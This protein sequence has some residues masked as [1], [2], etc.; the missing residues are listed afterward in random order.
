MTLEAIQLSRTDERTG[1]VLLH[2]C[3]LSIAAGDRLVITG[4]SGAGKSVLMRA[5]AW[6]DRPLGELRWN[7]AA[8]GRARVPAYRAAVAYVRQRPALLDGSV[9][10][11]LRVPFGLHLYRHRRYEASIA[12]DYLSRAGRDA[13]F[14]AQRADDLS[15]GEQQLVAL[16]RTLQLDPKVLLLDEPTASLDPQTA[17]AVEAMIDHWVSRTPRAAWA[18]VTHDL[19]QARRVGN[20]FASVRAGVVETSGAP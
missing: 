17:L 6:L 2:P 7:G 1:A 13:G 9:E 10:D 5:L 4:P 11:N 18:W 8:V 16:V 15:G 12:L 19:T 14:L 3:N 20:R